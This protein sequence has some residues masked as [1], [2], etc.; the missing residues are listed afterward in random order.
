MSTAGNS[1][2][3]T[4]KTIATPIKILGFNRGKV[5]FIYVRRDALPK[6]LDDSSNLGLM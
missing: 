1:F 6:V 2:M 5:T 4:K 3:V